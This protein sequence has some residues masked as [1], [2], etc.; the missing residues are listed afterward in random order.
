[1][2]PRVASVDPIQVDT[3]KDQDVVRVTV[4]V[5]QS[6]CAKAYDDVVAH[7]RRDYTVPGFRNNKKVPVDLLI[8]QA[9]GEEAFKYA[10]VE[11]V[12][13]DTLK[14]AFTEYA[15]QL[16][17]GSTA[18][19]S[20]AEELMRG[21]SRDRELTYVA[22]AEV[23]DLGIAFSAPYTGLAV[24]IDA[25]LNQEKEDKEVAKAIRRVLKE[26]GGDL[27]VN[28]ERGLRIGDTAIIG[29]EVR[30][31]GTQTPVPGLARDKLE[32]DCE[33]ADSFLP[34]VL[35]QME[36]M[37]P[38]E[39]RNF[40][41]AFPSPW[42]PEELAGR[43]CEVTVK[44]RE[45]L[46]WELPELTLEVA[47]SV[48]PDVTSVEDFEAKAREAIQ[49]EAS[50]EL[51]SRIQSAILER[52][53]SITTT[54]RIPQGPF[55][56]FCYGQYEQK[57]REA[58]DDGS[59]PREKLEEMADERIVKAWISEREASLQEQ[60]RVLLALDKIYADEGLNIDEELISE[61]VESGLKQYAD[62]GEAPPDAEL[63]RSFYEGEAKNYATMAFLQESAQVTIK[64]I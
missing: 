49:Y 8:K 30:D 32:L 61:Q 33:D 12:L 15:D 58:I 62:A 17:D 48:V 60:F 51:Q 47:R 26:R 42:E 7:L 21:F 31:A 6:R 56:R 14:D 19:E 46:T 37:R 5:P 29:F 9:G 55:E 27:K 45:L 13:D 25:V 34:G 44:L 50:A 20:P 39:Q 40:A 23:G 3:Q 59:L 57:V 63:V 16:L 1:M 10:C 36:G 4:T 53:A 64:P 54:R 28:A 52:L 11:A 38:G 18:I 43:A 41:F 2:A 22:T 35:E 24:S